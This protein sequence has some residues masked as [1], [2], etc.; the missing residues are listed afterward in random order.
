MFSE[1]SR[2]AQNSA[3]TVTNSITFLSNIIQTFLFSYLLVIE[4]QR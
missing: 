4:T 1:R 2:K 3:A